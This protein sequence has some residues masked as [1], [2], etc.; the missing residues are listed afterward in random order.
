MIGRSRPFFSFRCSQLQHMI[1]TRNMSVSHPYHLV[2][3]SPWPLLMSF[4]LLLLGLVICS[5]LTHRLTSFTYPILC[6]TLIGLITYQWFRD[7][8]REAQGG[9][10]TK[11]VQQGIYISFLIFLATEVMLFFSFFWA[12]FH[13]SLAPAIELGAVWPPVGLNAISTFGLPLF[14]T[15]LLLSSGFVLTWG[16]HAL[17]CN[18]KEEALIGIFASAFLGFIFTY[19]QYMEYNFSEF[20]IADS[21]FGSVFFITTGLHFVHVLA[22]AIF[23][24][25]SGLRLFFDNFTSEHHL[26]L[27]FAITYWHLVDVVWIALYIIF[28]WWGGV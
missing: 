28:Y 15:T 23:L 12:F 16:H 4:A 25:V 6:F 1:Q 18:K 19:A 17:I 2:T 26:G 7:V 9:F 10:H 11:V 22:G 5:W 8:I 14:G 27:E 20:S 24:V 3:V 21:V 13:S